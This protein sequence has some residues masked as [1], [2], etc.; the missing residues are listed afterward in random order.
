MCPWHKRGRCLFKQCAP[1]PVGVTGEDVPVEQQLQDLRRALRRLV[2]AVMCRDGEQ[3]EPLGNTVFYECVDTD[4]APTMITT[5][6][7]FDKNRDGIPD[8]T[9]SGAAI[10]LLQDMHTK[11]AADAGAEVETSEAYSQRS[12]EQAQND[13]H[14]KEALTSN[15]ASTKAV[16]E[17][18][19][20]KFKSMAVPSEDTNRGGMRQVACP[21]CGCPTCVEDDAC[22]E[23]GEYSHIRDSAA[24]AWYACIRCTKAAAQQA[25]LP[26]EARRRRGRGRTGN[27]IPMTILFF[28]SQ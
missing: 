8:V 19:T 15:I 27:F 28:V 6:P 7:S 21:K 2:A 26:R 25:R 10:G 4:D 9:Q 16:I 20:S 13:G 18:N 5:V 3:P 22:D 17:E 12:N 23:C 24:C 14:W 11:V 1:P